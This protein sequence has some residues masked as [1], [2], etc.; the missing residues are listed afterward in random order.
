VSNPKVTV[1]Q[2]SGPFKKQEIF[3]KD[4]ASTF[5]EEQIRT[6]AYQIYESRGRTGNDADKGLESGAVRTN[7]PHGRQ[8]DRRAPRS[9]LSLHGC[10]LERG[11]GSTLSEILKGLLSRFPPVARFLNRRAAFVVRTP[12]AIS[13]E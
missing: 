4:S 10:D 12:S 7:G 9:E 2:E 8:I 6:R 13:M 3:K 11:R 5:S 1:G